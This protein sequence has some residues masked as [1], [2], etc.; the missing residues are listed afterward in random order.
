[1]DIRNSEVSCRIFN[2]LISITNASGCATERLQTP[3]VIRAEPFPTCPRI[4]SIRKIWKKPQWYRYSVHIVWTRQWCPR[5][6]SCS[7]IGNDVAMKDPGR[8]LTAHTVNYID[9]R[10]H[11]EIVMNKIIFSGFLVNTLFGILILTFLV[12]IYK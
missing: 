8:S 6:R 4:A 3:C 9:Y 11:K 2:E 12:G 7:S 5:E 1:M 10:V